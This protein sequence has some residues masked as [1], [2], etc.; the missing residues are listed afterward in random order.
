MVALDIVTKRLALAELQY[1][2]PEPVIGDLLRW[3]LVFNRGAAFGTTVGE[4]SRWVF[5][6]LAA[7]IL[8]VLVRMAHQATRDETGKLFALGLVCGGAIGNLIDRLRW[9]R[10]VVDFVDVGI[11]GHRFWVFNVADSAVT[12]GAVMLVLILWREDRHA[13]PAPARRDERQRTT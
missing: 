4:W 7:G 8:V 3:T 1:G 11:G 12:I 9:S 6:A 10:G 13:A 2:V 5:T